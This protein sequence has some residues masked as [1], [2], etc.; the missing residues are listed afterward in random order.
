MTHCE[1]NHGQTLSRYSDAEP[2]NQV[3]N[4]HLQSAPQRLEI[5]PEPLSA[6]SRL[7]FCSGM[8][9]SEVL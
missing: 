7:G 9:L 1:T 4:R 5:H 6:L 3:Q 2:T 8:S